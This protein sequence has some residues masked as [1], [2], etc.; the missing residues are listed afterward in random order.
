MLSIIEED[1][2]Y[3][4]IKSSAKKQASIKIDRDSYKDRLKGFWLGG[5]IANWT[6][7][8]TELS[9]NNPPFYTDKDW[10]T[11]NEERKVT[12]EFILNQDPW[13]ADDDTDIEYVYQHAMELYNTHLLTSEQI[14]TVWKKHIGLPMLWVSNVAAAGQ[15]QRGALPPATS[16][17]ENNPMWDM[18]DAQLT[19]EIFGALAPGRPDVALKMG[20]L[21]IRTTAYMD[22]EWASEFYIIMHALVASVDTSLSKKNQVFWMADQARNRIPDWSYMADMFDFV[23]KEYELNPD[24]NNWEE[25]RDKLYERYQAKSTAGYT[26]K[27]AW[28]AGINFASSIV[29]LL[30]GEGDYKRTIQIGT[31]TGWDSDNPTATWGGL[32]GL[33]YGHE[34]L[35]KHF[36]KF[37]FSNGYW[38]ERTR[39]NLPI[40]TD[41]IN[42]MA[43]RGLTIIDKVVVESMGGS[44]KNGKWFIPEIGKKIEKV[45]L[46]KIEVPWSTIEDSDPRWKYKGFEILSEQWYNSDWTLTKGYKNA[47]AEFSFKGSGVIYFA[48][49]NDKSGKVTIYLDN[50]YQGSYDLNS[51]SDQ[52]FVKIWGTSQLDYGNH[53]IRIVGDKTKRE[54]SIDM[55]SIIKNANPEAYFEFQKKSKK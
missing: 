24:K 17:P 38:I 40:P 46:N 42:D 51:E 16:L 1:I 34:A 2:L 54:K 12:I 9:R 47:E 4:S 37:D 53:T 36:E 48:Q 22:A 5:C 50:K 28:D 11:Y 44:I 20:H 31:L 14:G 3:D 13:K 49:K 43:E 30:Y 26:Y 18:I 35:Q 10:D 21:P 29:S 55:L 41:N 52:Y 23:K 7:L 33:L 8:T 27:Y 25:T 15:I 6:G 19:T 45:M 32:L 39:P